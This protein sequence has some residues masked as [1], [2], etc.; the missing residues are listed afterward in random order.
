M[1]IKVVIEIDKDLNVTKSVQGAKGK[2]CET[3]TSFLD[4]AMHLTDVKKTLTAD[5]HKGDI[6][7][8]NKITA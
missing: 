3:L 8:G 5:Y 4:K 2:Q 7:D 6:D 1:A